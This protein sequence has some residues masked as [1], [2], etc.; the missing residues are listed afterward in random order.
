MSSA[1]DAAPPRSLPRRLF[2]L[3]LRVARG[4]RSNGGL[5]LANAIAYD[6]LLSVVPLLLLATA[7]FARLV[8]RER[9]LY[10]VRHEVLSI[11][12]QQNA[13]P[14]ID[15]LSGLLE[16]P[17]ATSALG[18]LTLL[19]FSAMG[20]RTL[21]RALVAIFKH[22][23][24]EERPRSL[25]A[26]SA[27]AVGYVFAIGLISALQALLLV[28]IDQ[29]PWLAERVPAWTSWFATIGLA[30]LLASFYLLM[31]SGRGSLRAAAIGGLSAAVT[32]RVV[33]VGLAL[34]LQYVARINVI[35]GSL[36]ALVVV[37]LSFE[38]IAVITLL[39]AQL[40]A[41]LEQGW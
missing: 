40:T 3:V 29:V 38:I 15:A 1:I 21:Q 4:F 11:V 25:L 41:E 8:D 20:F 36:S 33:Q 32:W 22:R 27:I 26:S 39:G 34:Y 28:R 2:A 12:P 16:A 19:L 24:G 30:A 13:G 7:L 23:H 6:G 31:P 5:L 10:V 14:F 35:Y 9:F 18:L 17:S 37:L